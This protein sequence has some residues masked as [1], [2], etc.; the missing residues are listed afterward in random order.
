MRIIV[1]FVRAE[2]HWVPDTGVQQNFLVFSF[3]GMEHRLPCEEADIIR[4]IR[5]ASSPTGEPVDVQPADDDPTPDDWRDEADGLDV[6]AGALH[7]MD[8]ASGDLVFGGDV[9]PTALASLQEAPAPVAPR[10]TQDPVLL[11]KA[12]INETM[13]HRPR[14]RGQ[15]LEAKKQMREAARRA[16]GSRPG[17]GRPQPVL[18]ETQRNQAAGDD[19]LFSQG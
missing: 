2:Q 11:R 19:D 16:P 9:N 5:E 7:R 4:A 17:A 12:M 1:D 13:S 18:Q 6:H 14:S 8:D 15:I 3:A 10:P